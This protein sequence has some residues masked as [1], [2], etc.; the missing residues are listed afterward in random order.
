MEFQRR[1]R[2]IVEGKDDGRWPVTAKV[3]QGLSMAYK[4]AVTLRADLY[5]T[6]LL[7]SCHL[8]CKVLSVGNL[9]TG[10]TGKTPMVC[11]I[12]RL[13]QDMGKQA[14]VIS[15]GYKGKFE[16]QGGVVSDTER[17]ML[18]PLDAGDEP[19]MM[20]RALP[21]I[22]VLVGQDRVKSGRYA[23]AQFN[24]DVIILDDGFQHLRLNRNL[25]L[26][27]LDAGQ[28]YGNGHLLPRGK[29]REPL[30]A[31]SRADA[32]ILTRSQASP[33]EYYHDLAAQVYPRPVIRAFHIPVLRGIVPDAA[34]FVGGACPALK[35]FI[36]DDLAG[37]K[38]LAFSGLA[39]NDSFGDTLLSFKVRL[40]HSMGFSDHH[41]YTLEDMRHIGDEAAGKACDFIATSEKDFMRIPSGTQLP[42]GLVVLGVDISFGESET[43]MRQ[44]VSDTLFGP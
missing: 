34:R 31:L 33:P 22:P 30:S 24:P 4:G 28:P 21:G 19:Y 42:M 37:K 29:L 25:D 12:A 2:Q 40:A 23:I 10:G 16:K 18:H 36:I 38:I 11:Y 35:T 26:L 1:I 20:A 41:Q 32:V 39:N 14:A 17:I 44:L 27:L 7:A 8:D 15:R 3:M 9:T 5:R 6:N 13:L 43:R